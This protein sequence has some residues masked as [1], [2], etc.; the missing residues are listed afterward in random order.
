MIVLGQC[1]WLRS[2]W[3]PFMDSTLGWRTQSLAFRLY[4]YHQVCNSSILLCQSVTKSDIEKVDISAHWSQASVKTYF[5][6]CFWQKSTAETLWQS[7]EVS[8]EDTG[9][10]WM[11]PRG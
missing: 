5:W 3:P 11:N 2:R 8:F 9:L 6:G 4:L 1:F 10:L 7:K